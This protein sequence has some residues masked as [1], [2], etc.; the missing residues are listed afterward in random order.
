M[1]RVLFRGGVVVDG[2]GAEPTRGDVLVVRPGERLAGDGVVLGGASYVDESMV[3]GEP[4]PVAKRAGDEVVQIYVRDV[5]SSVARPVLE[6]KAFRRVTLAPGLAER[7]IRLPCEYQRLVV[8]G[9]KVGR[10]FVQGRGLCVFA[11]LDAGVPVEVAGLEEQRVAVD[12]AFKS[13]LSG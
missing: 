11:D 12:R 1:D 6:L 8:V 4:T 3:T 2:T 10:S 7:A 13:G 9:P 5:V